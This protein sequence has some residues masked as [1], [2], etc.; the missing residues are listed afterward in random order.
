MVKNI[1]LDLDGQYIREKENF[2]RKLEEKYSIMDTC[3]VSSKI[4][5][6]VVLTDK[7]PAEQWDEYAVIGIEH[8][9]RIGRISYVLED[10]EDITDYDIELAYAR[11]NKLSCIIAA[12]EDICIREMKAEDIPA[13]K[14]IYDEPEII[15]NVPMLEDTETEIE[16]TNAYIKYMYGFY[17]YGMWIIED[18]HTGK[19]IGR[20]GIEHRELEK[21]TYYELGYLVAKKYRGRGYGYRAAQMAVQFAKEYGMKELITCIREKNIPSIRLSEKL[22]FVFW[23]AVMNGTEKICIFRKQL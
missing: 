19:I 5:G 17:G 3:A 12:D 16:K 1:F 13:L 6:A 8:S 20:T 7:S 18:K 21:N 4:T 14:S 2:I 10:L 23:K 15:K 9:G 22:G 11:K